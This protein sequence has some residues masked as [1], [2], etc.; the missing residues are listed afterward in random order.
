[1]ANFSKPITQENFPKAWRSVRRR[2]KLAKVK[3]AIRRIA[4]PVG[5]IL[6]FPA[7]LMLAFGGAASFTTP[8][9]QALLA[10]APVIAPMWNQLREILFSS[11]SST[12]DYILRGAAF[13]YAVPFCAFLAAA[14]LITI[15]YHPKAFSL[16][17][18]IHQDAQALWTMARYARTDAKRKGGDLSGTL[19]LI[20]G[21]IA[22]LTSLFIIFYW[23][24][25]PGGENLLAGIGVYQTLRLFGIALILIFAYTPVAYPLNLL[26]KL[27][28][29]CPG[30]KK[31]AD[32][33]EIF[34]RGLRRGAVPMTPMAAPVAAAAAAAEAPAKPAEAAPAPTEEPQEVPSEAP[35]EVP[36]EAPEEVPAE[37]PSETPAE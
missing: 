5:E 32:S 21:I 29:W 34:C 25:F 3:A 36:T 26:M 14:L 18:N 20:T 7:F 8:G 22:A 31:M 24:L 23:L 19:S 37:E 10:K 6:F 2:Y 9:I 11:A 13:L 35:E 1:M 17:G 16:S 27:I 28:C 4:V 15:V 33:A 12:L 30:A